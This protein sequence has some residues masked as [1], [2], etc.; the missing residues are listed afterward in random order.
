VRK[1]RLFE[2]EV[3]IPE[4]IRPAVDAW[5]AYKAKRRQSYKTAEG[6][7]DLVER[8]VAMG[9]ER[10]MAAVKWSRSNEYS[11][12][13]EESKEGKAKG[14]DLPPPTWAV[15]IMTPSELEAWAFM[16]RADRAF[17]LENL[18]LRSGRRQ[19]MKDEADQQG[20]II[21]YYGD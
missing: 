11:G 18:S 7:A 13:Y 21:T 5:L 8:M 2:P 20:M 10:A 3:P 15:P 14:L 16:L 4:A 12:L 17:F 1:P 9:P 19:S 6:L